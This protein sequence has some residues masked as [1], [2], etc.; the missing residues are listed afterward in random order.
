MKK[1]LQADLDMDLNVPKFNVFFP[2]TSFSLDTT[3]SALK[4]AVREDPVL[5]DLVLPQWGPGFQRMEGNIDLR[6][7]SKELDSG[8]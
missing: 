8:D 7:L 4:R 6:L 1:N 2:N 3:R 5:A